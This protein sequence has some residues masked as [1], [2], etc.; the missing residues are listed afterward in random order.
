MKEDPRTDISYSDTSTSGGGTGPTLAAPSA[1]SQA[2]DNFFGSTVSAP[3]SGSASGHGPTPAT[4]ASQAQAS[5]GSF[6]DLNDE[7]E[8]LEDAKE[9]SADDDFQT[10]SRSGLDDFN[11][12][13]DSS[14][15]SSQTKGASG[16]TAPFGQESSYDF[17]NTSSVST[18]AA[19]PGESGNS[20]LSKPSQP[21]GSHDW[22][23]IFATLDAPSESLTV[24]T[25]PPSK[26]PEP[27]PSREKSTTEDGKDDDPILKDLTSMGY[28]RA[29]ALLA[30]EKYDYNLERVGP[31][32][33]ETFPKSVSKSNSSM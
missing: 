14:P 11:P 25:P 26:Q 5:K 32:M 20:S 30:L 19:G 4:S 16:T 3:T 15:P 31:C 1:T 27:S 8:G 17:G 22:D 12:V 21:A 10:I 2:A 13:F 28:S 29:D 24:S 33:A 6:E 18:T 9:G 23:A 7:F